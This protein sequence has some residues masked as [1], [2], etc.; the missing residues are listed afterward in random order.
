MKAGKQEYTLRY[1][2]ETDLMEMIDEKQ[3]NRQTEIRETKIGSETDKKKEKEKR[4]RKKYLLAVELGGGGGLGQ[5]NYKM[6]YEYLLM[7]KTKEIQ[8]LHEP[9]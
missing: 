9:A 4:K 7:P 3:T 5:G 1:W 6:S 8:R 2:V